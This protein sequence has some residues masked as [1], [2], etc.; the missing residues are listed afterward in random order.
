MHSYGF[1]VWNYSHDII[2]IPP[3]LEEA[4]AGYRFCFCHKWVGKTKVTKQ[5]LQSLLEIL[6]HVSKCVSPAR[7]F[8]NRMLSFLR[9]AGD[10][11]LS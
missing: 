1:P 9:A 4:E 5:E 2:G 11:M 6:L 8:V 3:S 10:N 7:L